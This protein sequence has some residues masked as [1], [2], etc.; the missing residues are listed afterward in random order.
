[1]LN[2][3][4]TA[5]ASRIEELY[6]TRPIIYFDSL[7]QDFRAPCFFINLLQASVKPQLFNRYE[8]QMD[9]D[10]LYYP[11]SE[12]EDDV[13]ELNEV[14]YLLDFGLEYIK[15]SDGPLRGYD[16]SHR[17]TDDVLHF[18]ITYRIFVRKELEKSPFMQNLVQKY[19]IKT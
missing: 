3:V 16:I 9:F 17:V 11:Q 10:I 5:I 7:P 1:M 8:L 18:M 15:L 6:D 4:Y 14:A 2:D 19:R 13:T 12:K